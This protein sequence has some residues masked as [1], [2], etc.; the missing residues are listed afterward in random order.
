[1]RA[2]LS[3]LS[4]RKDEDGGGI[5]QAFSRRNNELTAWSALL[6]VESF[7]CSIL[8]FY[9]TPYTTQKKGKTQM[10]SACMQN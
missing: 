9:K 8:D 7:H 3:N 1:M 4:F 6:I 2:P 5:I 10:L